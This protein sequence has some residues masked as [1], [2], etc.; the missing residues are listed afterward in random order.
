MVAVDAGIKPSFLFDYAF[1]AASTIFDWINRLHAEKLTSNLLTVLDIEEHVFIC[2]FNQLQCSLLQAKSADNKHPIVIDISSNLKHPVSLTSAESL[3][4]I[5]LCLEGVIGDFLQ[6][7]EQPSE[8]VAVE[9]FAD[10]NRTTLFGL[11]LSYPVLYWYSSTS[12]GNCLGMISLNN[13][14]VLLKLQN[15][16]TLVYSFSFPVQF[17][18]I[19]DEVVRIW[20]KE[21]CSRQSGFALNFSSNI[22]ISPVVSMW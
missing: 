14:T 2:N 1:I 22:V 8:V 17:K 11:L 15:E 6:L 12:C 21:I 3:N 13:T 20:W 19:C 10:I 9:I 16:K 5:T 4:I 18:N 7:N